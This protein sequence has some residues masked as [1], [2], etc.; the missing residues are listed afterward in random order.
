MYIVCVVNTDDVLCLGNALFVLR[1]VYS[2]CGWVGG[3]VWGVG[4]GVC[5]CVVGGGGRGGGWVGVG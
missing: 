2:G 1:R 5:V 3:W 4:V